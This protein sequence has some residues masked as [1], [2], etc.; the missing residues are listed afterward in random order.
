MSTAPSMESILQFWQQIILDE[1]MPVQN[2]MKASELLYRSLQ[3]EPKE[4]VLPK[5]QSDAD[6]KTRI[7]QAEAIIRKY[8]KKR[9]ESE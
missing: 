6:L 7:E 4:Q 9:R 8:A 2:R 5:E 1:E 3:L